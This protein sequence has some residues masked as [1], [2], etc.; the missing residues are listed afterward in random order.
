MRPGRARLLGVGSLTPSLMFPDAPVIAKDVPGFEAVAWFG[1]FAPRG[2]PKDL[3]TRI[4]QDIAAVLQLP[5]V[6]QRLFDIG[7][8]P[9]GQT[10]EE[11]DAR[12]RAEIAKWQKVAQ[13]AGIKPQ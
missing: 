11:F 12:V 6:K 10:P 2:T 5:D 1:L 3:V 9:G 4:R 8:E 7:A 13:A